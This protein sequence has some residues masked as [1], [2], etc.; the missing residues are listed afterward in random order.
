MNL[1]EK[2][3]HPQVYAAAKPWLVV[4]TDNV[5]KV[6]FRSGHIPTSSCSV[7]S[8][9]RPTVIQLDCVNS[10]PPPHHGHMSRYT[11]SQ[12]P[13]GSRQEWRLLVG[14][15]ERTSNAG[16]VSMAPI[17]RLPTALHTRSCSWEAA[18]KPHPPNTFLGLF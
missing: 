8:L 13:G 14:G 5:F 2:K 11:V 1:G 4:S 3:Y 7:A 15:G 6:F 18:R 10:S 9:S 16:P 12:G 17:P